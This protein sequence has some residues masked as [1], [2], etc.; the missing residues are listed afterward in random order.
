VTATTIDMTRATCKVLDLWNGSSN[1]APPSGWETIGFDDSGWSASATPNRDFGSDGSQLNFRTIPGIG[2][3]YTDL[4]PAT[5]EAVWPTTSP[6]PDGLSSP[7][8]AQ[9][10][11]I[12]WHFS[13]SGT[14]T[15]LGHAAWQGG[16]FSIP[17]GGIFYLNGVLINNGAG[18]ALLSTFAAAFASAYVVGDNLWAAW[19]TMTGFWFDYAWYTARFDLDIAAGGRRGWSAVIG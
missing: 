2:L 3:T 19:I 4:A 17:A 13:I 8:I 12:R 5:A 1:N 7:F 16:F 18:S 10:A 9:T 14:A 11:L 15:V 6:S